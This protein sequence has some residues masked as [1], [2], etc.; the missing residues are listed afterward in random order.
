MSA[1]MTLV[2]FTKALDKYGVKY[3]TI[4]NPV[5]WRRD[6]AHGAW[7][8]VH[9]VVIH[10]TGDDAP[11]FMDRKTVHDGRPDLP[12][13]LCTGGINDDGVLDII[14]LGRSNHAGGG[15][16]QV[17]REVITESY[18][19]YPTPPKYH[20]GSPGAADGNSVFYGFETYYSG[21]HAPTLPQYQTMVGVCAAICDF[22]GWSS[23]S[24]IGH[25]EWSDWKPDPGNVDMAKFR[26]DVQ[27]RMA[28]PSISPT[29]H[30]APIPA[31]SPAPAKPVTRGVHID[32]ALHDLQQAV[33]PFG[34]LREKRI[35]AAIAAIKAISP[36]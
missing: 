3:R 30:P 4:G 8:S 9:G 6:P 32:N 12:G 22:Y 26:D 10:H 14:S 33:A 23:K 2:Q 25:K 5:Q 19:R 11:D 15:D 36:I 18:G 27:V 13:P 34:S 35:Q 21:S 7:G 1:P 17:L 20:E 29:P 31:P 24:V 28:S 16:P